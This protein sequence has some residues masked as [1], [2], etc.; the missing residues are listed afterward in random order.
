[1]GAM[2]EADDERYRLGHILSDLLR[3]CCEGC[4]PFRHQLL[5][6]A[7][8]VKKLPANSAN[9]LPLIDLALAEEADM[10]RS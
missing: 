1:M 3:L 5:A 9:L 2:G 10:A 7:L 6:A 4:A 8:Q